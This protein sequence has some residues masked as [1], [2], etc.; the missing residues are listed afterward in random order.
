VQV[1]VVLMNV[2]SA[3]TTWC[4]A[5]PEIDI[6]RN[7]LIQHGNGVWRIPHSAIFNS[8]RVTGPHKMVVNVAFV[9]DMDLAKY[10]DRWSRKY[11]THEKNHKWPSRK[12]I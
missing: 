12:T 3:Y 5:M 11:S 1:H 2:G 7:S 10:P 6:R 9:G 8:R 4:E